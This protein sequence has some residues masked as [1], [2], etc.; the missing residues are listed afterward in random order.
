M[1]VEFPVFCGELRV[2][3]EDRFAVVDA[4]VLLIKDVG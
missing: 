3:V 1:R 4:H 2:G